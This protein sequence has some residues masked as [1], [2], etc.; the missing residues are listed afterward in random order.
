MNKWYVRLEAE[1]PA[2][3]H[4]AIRGRASGSVVVVLLK[5]E[6]WRRVVDTT[7]G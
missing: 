1:H 2:I 3:G 7:K 4:T 6:P 5:A